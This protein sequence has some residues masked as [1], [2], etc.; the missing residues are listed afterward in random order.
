MDGQVRCNEEVITLNTCNHCTT[1]L[2]PLVKDYQNVTD[3]KKRNQR[4]FEG[5]ASI[6]V[7]TEALAQRY[8][9]QFSDISFLIYRFE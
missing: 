8:R 5:A 9:K 1:Q 3:W 6:S 4:W 7:S 2:G